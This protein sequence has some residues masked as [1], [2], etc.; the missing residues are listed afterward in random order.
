MGRRALRRS[1][2][3]WMNGVLVGE[4][5][6]LPGGVHELS[7][8]TE[9]LLSPACR[10]LS[11]SLPI[12]FDGQPLRGPTVQNFF[13]N[14]LP[15]SQAILRRIQQRFATSSQEAFALLSAIGRDCVGAVQLL[16]PGEEAAKPEQTSLRLEA[17]DESGVARCLRQTVS[18]GVTPGKYDEEHEFRISI[19]GAQ[20]KTALS[21]F[22][23]RWWIPSGATPSTHIFKLPLG[24]V[25]NALADMRESVEN[26]WLCGRILE[27]F[28]LPVARSEIMQF[29]EQRALVV[30]RFDRRWVEEGGFWLRLP[31]E[32]MCQAK[33][34]PPSQKYEADGGP[35]IQDIAQLL[36]RSETPS[37]DL[38]DF[39]KAQLVMWLLAATDG[40]AKNFSIHL[41]PGGR[42]RMTPLYDV[43]SMWPIT[44]R[45]ANLL[46]DRKL[47]MA[48]AQRG[49]NAHYRLREIRRRH[50]VE[51]ARRCGYPADEFDAQIADVIAFAPTA[52]ARVES[53]LPSDFPPGLFEKIRSGVLDNA[54]RLAADA[55]TPL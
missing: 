49:R 46:E 7:Y 51:T 50:F 36:Q 29:E 23:G 20:E 31:Q 15:D 24:L 30:E 13:E 17:L 55:P 10:P 41:L 44:G 8:A 34:L 47:A 21:R 39:L 19:A 26:E 3:I 6:I 5:A 33:G 27:E 4:W 22:D 38:P 35:G 2:N 45:G 53:R 37:R 32:D 52:L 48:M 11:L 9:W 43:L 40:H 16:P 18:G 1:L 14:L 42:Y 25:G 28:G 12:N 54:R